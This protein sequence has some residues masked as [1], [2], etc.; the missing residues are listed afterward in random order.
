[1]VC[2][3]GAS[4]NTAEPGEERGRGYKKRGLYKRMQD[5]KRR[6]IDAIDARTA[7][8]KDALKFRDN[9][10][11][12]NGGE[13]LVDT[14]KGIIDVATVNRWL[15]RSGTTYMLTELPSPINKRKKCFH[16]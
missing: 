14:M 9:V 7:E 12:Q 6:G 15:W 5:A 2:A 3:C 8:G 1:M 10:I 4:M 11:D 13:D 16:G